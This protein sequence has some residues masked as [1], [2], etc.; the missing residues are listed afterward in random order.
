MICE[1]CLWD[2]LITAK[3][4][5]FGRYYDD[6]NKGVGWSWS[7]S[8]DPVCYRCFMSDLTD[9][10]EFVVSYILRSMGYINGSGYCR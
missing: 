6:W 2:G 4:K 1:E 3:D 7:W 8:G 9:M 10:E 5:A